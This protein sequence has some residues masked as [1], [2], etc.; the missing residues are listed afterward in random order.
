MLWQALLILGSVPCLRGAQLREAGW[1]TGMIPG[2]R[3]FLLLFADEALYDVAEALPLFSLGFG[4]TKSECVGERGMGEKR[5]ED[6]RK[7]KR[8]RE[9]AGETRVACLAN[10]FAVQ[11]KLV[12]EDADTQCCSITFF[13]SGAV[14]RWLNEH[15]EYGGVGGCMRNRGGW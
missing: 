11:Q 4:R 9:M 6:L 12:F 2:L 1:P 10:C 3:M 15:A 8:E 13:L 7:Y 5:G 14:V